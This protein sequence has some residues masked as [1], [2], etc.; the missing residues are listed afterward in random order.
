MAKKQRVLRCIITDPHR[1]PGNEIVVTISNSGVD[2]EQGNKKRKSGRR[3]SRSLKGLTKLCKF[4]NRELGEIEAT[5]CLL[6]ILRDQMLRFS[7]TLFIIRS[8]GRIA[9]ANNVRRRPRSKKR[10]VNVANHC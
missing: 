6:E 2:V 9:Q 8:M 5:K 7:T 10:A 4:L 1:Q 3:F